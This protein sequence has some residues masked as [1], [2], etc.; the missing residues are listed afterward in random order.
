[1]V[2]R[3]YGA[4]WVTLGQEVKGAVRPSRAQS[5]QQV[6]DGLRTRLALHPVEIIGMEGIAAG[7]VLGTREP[8]L[9]HSKLEG[10]GA[11]LAFTV[12]STNK[13]LSDNLLK[14]CITQFTVESK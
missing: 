8:V 6:M 2:T 7:E 5:M 13:T 4:K 11:S 3:E 12:R 14:E 10:A 1:M 9:V